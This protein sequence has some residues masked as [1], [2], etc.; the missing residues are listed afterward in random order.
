MLAVTGR[1]INTGAG[2][3]AVLPV[4]DHAGSAL[5][6]TLDAR[7]LCVQLAVVGLIGTYE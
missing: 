2:V 3:F 7:R 5:G 4:R 6:M 1:T